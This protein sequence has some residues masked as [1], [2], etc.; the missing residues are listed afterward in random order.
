MGVLQV[1]VWAAP[2]GMTGIVSSR[3]TSTIVTLSA[4]ASVDNSLSW[5]GMPVLI[6]VESFSVCHCANS[7]VPPE[8]SG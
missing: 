6:D 8:L 1:F 2:Q 7:L 4:R 5:P 3:L